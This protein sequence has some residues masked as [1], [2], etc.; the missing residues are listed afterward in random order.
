MRTHVSMFKPPGGY[1]FQKLM[2]KSYLTDRQMMVLEFIQAY[3]K[4]KGYAP[5]YQD[6]AAGLKMKS[7]SNIHRIVTRLRLLGIISI[8]PRK[9]RAIKVVGQAIK[10]IV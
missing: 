2:T 4:M 7:R 10:R 3:I 9:A 8:K 5:S 6:V 1:I